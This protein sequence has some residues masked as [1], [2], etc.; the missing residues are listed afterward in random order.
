MV[1]AGLVLLAVALVAAVVAANPGIFQREFK[2][3]FLLVS[4]VQLS[5]QVDATRYAG[6]LGPPMSWLCMRQHC[7]HNEMI[8]TSSSCP[9]SEL[10]M[11]FH[12]C[13]ACC[14][15]IAACLSLAALLSIAFHCKLCR[16][17]CS[18]A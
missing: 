3:Q 4:F 7:R 2:A 16:L 13:I 1:L 14:C 8:I 9:S 11:M 12:D 6:N 18:T 5:N 17:G 10:L 15:Q